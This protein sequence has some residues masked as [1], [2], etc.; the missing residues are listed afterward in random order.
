MRD[1]NLVKFVDSAIHRNDQFVGE[2]SLAIVEE[3]VERTLKLLE[4]L[5]IL[6][7][8]CLHLWSNLLVEWELFDDEIE[9]VEEGLLHVF[10]NVVVKSWLNVVWLV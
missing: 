2:T 7:Q 3:M 6:D 4:Y 5:R 9:I 1:H 10:S 8:F